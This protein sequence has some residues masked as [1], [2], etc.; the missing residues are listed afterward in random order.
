MPRK[1]A[2]ES[3]ADLQEPDLRTQNFILS[4]RK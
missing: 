4:A 2:D 1:V 3:A